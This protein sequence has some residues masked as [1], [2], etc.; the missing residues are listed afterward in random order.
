VHVCAQGLRQ[1]E[2]EFLLWQSVSNYPFC[3][4]ITDLNSGGVAFFALPSVCSGE[5]M[6]VM[7]RVLPTMDDVWQFMSNLVK[8]LDVDALTSVLRSDARAGNLPEQLE[9]PRRVKP[10]L[11]GRTSQLNSSALSRADWFWQ[12]L[13]AMQA[14]E[15]DVAC[16]RDVDSFN[17]WLPPYP[18]ATPYHS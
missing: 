14:D 3:Q 13:S 17:D 9:Q 10:R 1:A 8:S 2:T 5:A 18:V 16:L 11:E 12:Q 7:Y 15:R 4:L 6:R